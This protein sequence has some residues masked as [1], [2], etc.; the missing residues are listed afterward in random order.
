MNRSGDAYANGYCSLIAM[1]HRPVRMR[2]SLPA[3]VEGAHDH[4][5]YRFHMACLLHHSDIRQKCPTGD[6]DDFRKPNA[7]RGRRSSLSS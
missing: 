3:S 1:A 5:G 6:P 2:P 7:H 4:R